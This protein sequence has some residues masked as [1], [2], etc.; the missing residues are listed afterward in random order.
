[1][2]EQEPNFQTG[3]PGWARSEMEGRVQK[4]VD[5]ERSR[6]G[7]GES[8]WGGEGLSEVPGSAALLP[9]PLPSPAP[10][11]RMSPDLSCGRA[12]TC[13]L[14]AEPCGLTWSGELSGPEGQVWNQR[15]RLYYWEGA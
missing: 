13:L 9:P 4:E 11:G 6:A 10:A 5:R 14:L 8:V 15:V 2:K 12:L 1:M 7:E 3:T